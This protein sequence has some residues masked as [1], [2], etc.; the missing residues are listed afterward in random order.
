[1]SYTQLEDLPNNFLHTPKYLRKLDLTGNYL[2]HIPT[3]LG[4]VHALETL[5][6]DDNKIVMLTEVK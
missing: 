1:M 2:D 5:V 6:L 3:T 4:D